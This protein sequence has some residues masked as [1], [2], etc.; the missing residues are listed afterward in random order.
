M[1]YKQTSVKVETI[2]RFHFF[3]F[4]RTK[5]LYIIWRKEKIVVPLHSQLRNS[6]N[7]NGALVQL[8][9]IHACHAWGHGFESRTHRL[10]ASECFT[11]RPFTFTPP[12]RRH[13]NYRPGTTQDR[14]NKET[15]PLG[16]ISFPP[17]LVS[18]YFISVPPL[19]KRP[20]WNIQTSLD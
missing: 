16:M 20:Q 5:K 18:Y 10:K 2:K 11:S 1:I 17:E 14:K 3:L 15:N 13:T 9:R 12:T 4:L 7:F 8:V 6:T 19:L